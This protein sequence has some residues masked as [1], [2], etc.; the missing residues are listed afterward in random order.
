MGL[1]Q[2]LYAKRFS[3]PSFESEKETY[4]QIIEAMNA[5]DFMGNAPFPY[6]TVSV[7]VGYWRKQNAIHQWFV[8]IC[9]DGNDDCRDAFVAR[10][11]LEELRDLCKQVLADKSLASDLLP[12]SEGFFF[13]GT[14]YDEWYIQGLEYTV[15]L[16]DD[17]LA[18]VPNEWDFVYGSSW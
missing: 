6:T 11:Q 2:Y 8:D 18:K 12:T 1:D 5:R 14:D 9:Q 17:L 13:G 16:I 15:K 7:T 4:E 3:S 10:E